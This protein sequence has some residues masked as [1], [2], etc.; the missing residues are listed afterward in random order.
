MPPEARTY[1]HD[2]IA[3]MRH[4]FDG[5]LSVNAAAITVGVSPETVRRYWRQMEWDRGPKMPAAEVPENSI[6]TPIARTTR[7]GAWVA[8]EGAPISVAAAHEAAFRKRGWLMQRRTENG[9]DLVW[10]AKGTA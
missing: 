9:F 10:K 3:L 2:E 6:W 7:D 8:C 4:A 5:H 1:T